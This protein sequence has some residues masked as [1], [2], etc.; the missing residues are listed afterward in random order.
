MWGLRN[1]FGFLSIGSIFYAISAISSIGVT[2]SNSIQCLSGLI[3]IFS[4]ICIIIGIYSIRKNKEQ[5]TNE[6]KKGLEWAILGIIGLCFIYCISMMFAIGF[7]GQVIDISRYSG[8][9][10]SDL[11]NVIRE[12]IID[13][14]AISMLGFIAYIFSIGS[15]HFWDRKKIFTLIIII[16]SCL[17]IIPSVLNAQHTYNILDELEEKYGNERLSDPDLMEQFQDDL[18]MK[19][20]YGYGI[21]IFLGYILVGIPNYVTWSILSDK[22]LKPDSYKREPVQQQRSI[23]CTQSGENTIKQPFN[24]R[25]RK[26]INDQKYGKPTR[27][28]YEE[29]RA[30]IFGQNQT[31]KINT[32]GKK[33]RYCRYCERQIHWR[34]TTCPWCKKFQI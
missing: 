25:F 1:C 15:L 4:I 14:L 19:I 17:I 28:D 26:P 29:I 18:S 20:N 7:A 12:N 33:A 22:D 13:L 34:D 8:S 31:K 11:F 23:K 16:G 9:T 32:T 2:Q 5:L 30:R 24:N 10:F 21:I 6:Q 3:T 27:G